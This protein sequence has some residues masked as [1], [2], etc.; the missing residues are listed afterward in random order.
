MDDDDGTAIFLRWSIR[1]FCSDLGAMAPLTVCIVTVSDRCSRG[2]AEDS[3][4]N[5]L[6]CEVDYGYRNDDD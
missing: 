6:G 1:L 2:E 3:S 5:N 4:G